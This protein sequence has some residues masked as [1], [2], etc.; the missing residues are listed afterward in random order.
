[1]KQTKTPF[2]PAWLVLAGTSLLVCVSFVL[3]M[4]V[5]SILLLPI[6]Q[7]FQVGIATSSLLFTVRSVATIFFLPFLAPM[8]KK[9]G[10]RKIFY[11]GVIGTSV[12]F[13]LQSKATSIWFLL[14]LVIPQAFFTLLNSLQTCSMII[15][16]WF[17]EKLGLAL[18][19]NAACT[20]IGAAILSPVFTR[21]LET[22]DW[23]TV[24]MYCGILYLV[25][26]GISC[27]PIRLDPSLTGHTPY[28]WKEGG[29]SVQH[30]SPA[31]QGVSTREAFRLPSFYLLAFSLVLL[32]I[33][34]IFN[35]QIASMAY[36][37]GFTA[38]VVG[39]VLSVVA[40]GTF[41]GKNVIGAVRDK[42]GGTPAISLAMGAAAVGVMMFFAAIQTV[43][44]TW[45]YLGAAVGGFGLAMGTIVPP[46]ATS[47][48]L[49]RKDYNSLYGITS[50]FV[51]L[52]SAFGS[53]IIGALFD[54]TGSYASVTILVAV[55]CV[56]LIPCFMLS[57]RAGQKN[58]KNQ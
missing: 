17:Q 21:I 31:A 36:S 33:A 53:P 22:S 18:G 52:G 27:I 56:I 26:G 49:G 40:V 19:F 10:A 7:S 16:N 35:T 29:E 20:G 32:G 57:I 1:M 14:L 12:C 51:A 41:V 58:W 34:A 13:F 5:M 47:S 2:H 8:L 25:I 4:N 37:I 6:A 43:S 24:L 45:L 3:P 42:S 30:I 55:I 11:L 28:G 38:E 23:R 39:P 15:N 48:A 46:L 9:F 50:I 54:S 44:L